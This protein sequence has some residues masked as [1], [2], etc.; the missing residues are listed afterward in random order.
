M[1][2]VNAAVE[3]WQRNMINAGESVKAGV[4]A[5][6]ESPMAKAAA[7]A[8]RYVSGVQQAVASGKWQQGLQS[9]SLQQWK[10]AVVAGIP[11]MT[12]GVTKAKPK[13]QAFMQAFLPYVDSVA[14]QVRNMPKGGV[15]NGIA[16][17][18]AMIRALADFK[19]R[20]G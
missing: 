1:I 13:M 2:N 20:K 14:Q 7:Q 3:K 17:A 12:A 5:V 8:D 6:Q 11:A 9:V 19:Y 18:S 16:R 10:D 4:A 15:E